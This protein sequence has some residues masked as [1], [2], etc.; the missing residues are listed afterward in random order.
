MISMTLHVLHVLT[1][2]ENTCKA[3][4][5]N[6]LTRLTPILT[7]KLSQKKKRKNTSIRYLFFLCILKRKIGCKRCKRCKV[8][9]K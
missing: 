5:F 1:P 8:I 4:D 3:R 7:D 6:D 9:E 2:V